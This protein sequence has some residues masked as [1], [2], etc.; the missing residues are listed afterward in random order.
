[1]T[2]PSNV[3]RCIKDDSPILYG[4]SGPHECSKCG[5]GIYL[6]DGLILPGYFWEKGEGGYLVYVENVDEDDEGEW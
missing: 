2:I 1:M 3:V 6:S 4:V 5:R